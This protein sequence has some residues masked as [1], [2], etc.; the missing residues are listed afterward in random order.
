[1]SEFIYAVTCS[2]W[3]DDGP[4]TVTFQML[5]RDEAEKLRRMSIRDNFH[6]VSVIG[7]PV[8]SAER[9]RHVMREA[10]ASQKGVA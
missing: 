2:F 8:V 4:E 9:A 6:V 3:T 5:T 1:M 10:A 7:R